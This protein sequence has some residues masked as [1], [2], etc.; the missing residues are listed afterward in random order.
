M[1]GPEIVG[2][3]VHSIQCE[4]IGELRLL[5]SRSKKEIVT[6][7]QMSKPRYGIGV[8]RR[9]TLAV[10]LSN[11]KIMAN[12]LNLRT[13]CEGASKAPPKFCGTFFCAEISPNVYSKVHAWRLLPLTLFSLVNPGRMF[14]W[15]ATF[16]SQKKS[17]Q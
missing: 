1:P 7:L 10:C 3:V 9:R 16:F 4:E 2:F 6:A 15:E 5:S 13:K 12:P 8:G 14:S 11:K 17:W